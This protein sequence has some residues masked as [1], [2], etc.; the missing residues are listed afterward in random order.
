MGWKGLTDYKLSIIMFK[1]FK[2]VKRF[3]FTV[4]GD[5]PLSYS[6]L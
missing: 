3:C 1:N 5:N 2:E 4:V 6:E